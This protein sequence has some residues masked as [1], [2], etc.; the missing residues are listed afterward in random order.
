METVDDRDADA[1]LAALLAHESQFRS[2]MDIEDA[3]A[4]DQVKAFEVRVRRRLAEHG[5]LA[6]VP[7]GEAFKVMTDL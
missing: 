1:K 4:D 3:S 5:D 2:T 7:Q 6:G